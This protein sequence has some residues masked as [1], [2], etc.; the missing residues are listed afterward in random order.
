[1]TAIQA[2]GP[3]FASEDPKVLVAVAGDGCPYLVRVTEWGWGC[4]SGGF[5]L[6]ILAAESAEDHLHWHQRVG[7]A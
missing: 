4:T 1:V 7:R 5:R 3:V 6:R 2:R